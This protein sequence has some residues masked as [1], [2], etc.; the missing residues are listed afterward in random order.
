MRPLITALVD[1]LADTLRQPYALFG[2]SLGALIAY[3]LSRELRRRCLPLP[4]VLIVSGRRAPTVKPREPPLHG[5]PDD[6]FVAELIRRYDAI[7]QVILNEP[8]LMALFLPMLKADFALFETHEHQE[9]RPLDCALAIY[10]GI[11]DSQTAEMDDWA[12]LVTGPCRRRHFQGG[13][14]YFA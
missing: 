9:A 14:F 3:E 1:A 6:A 8:D 13:H 10:G 4:R 7:P 5:L 2:H 12:E 11:A